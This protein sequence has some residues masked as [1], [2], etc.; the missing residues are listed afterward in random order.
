MHD[1]KIVSVAMRVMARFTWT[2]YM[3]QQHKYPRTM[4]SSCLN[5]TRCWEWC[6]E[7][8]CHGDFWHG[9]SKSMEWLLR[10]I[11]AAWTY[12]R[13]QKMIKMQNNK[14]ISHCSPPKHYTYILVRWFALP[15]P[16]GM[17]PL[18]PLL[19]RSLTWEHKAHC[20]YNVVAQRHTSVCLP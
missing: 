18:R 14:H 16:C 9:S 12:E 2:L 15:M 7:G 11:V 1:D 5:P 6:R 4:I 20:G 8:S 19:L 17:V 13:G 3:R 10:C